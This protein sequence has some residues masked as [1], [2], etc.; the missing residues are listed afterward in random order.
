MSNDDHRSIENLKKKILKIIML[1][2]VIDYEASFLQ[3]KRN[4][5][6][7]GKKENKFIFLFFF[8][9]CK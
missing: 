2:Y 4:V 7:R 3:I 5:G 8:G 6:K 9:T 1:I